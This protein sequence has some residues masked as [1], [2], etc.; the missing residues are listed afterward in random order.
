LVH[1]YTISDIRNTR[2]VIA[3]GRMFDCG[4]LWKSVGFRP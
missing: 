2:T 1:R 4:E 3:A